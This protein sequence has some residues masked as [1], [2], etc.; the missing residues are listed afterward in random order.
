[1]PVAPVVLPHQQAQLAQLEHRG[2]FETVD[3]PVNG[4]ARHSTLPIRF[5][6]GPDRFVT[7]R[8]PLFGEHNHDVLTRILG[9]SSDDVAA[10]EAREVIGDRPKGL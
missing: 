6:R 4:P 5:S 10:L 8:A 2:Y 7:R 9:L 3:H 1:M